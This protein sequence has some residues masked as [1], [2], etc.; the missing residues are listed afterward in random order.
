MNCCTSTCK[1]DENV[2]TICSARI[3][4]TAVP[5][6]RIVSN[7]SWPTVLGIAPVSR[8]L[9]NCLQSRRHTTTNSNLSVQTNENTPSS[10]PLFRLTGIEATTVDPRCSESCR[11]VD[12]WP[13]SCTSTK[14]SATTHTHLHRYKAVTLL[15]EHVRRLP[16]H[17]AVAAK[18]GH[19]AGEQPVGEEEQKLFFVRLFSVT[20]AKPRA[21]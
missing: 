19:S 3:I 13:S 1:F 9:S 17:G 15:P 6:H 8:L 21:S 5:T 18:R 16:E 10:T 20:V 12:C 4:V 2:G 14:T 7:D 11:P